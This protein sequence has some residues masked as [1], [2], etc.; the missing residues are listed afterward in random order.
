MVY[1][2]SGWLVV[3]FAAY[4]GLAIRSFLMQHLHGRHMKYPFDTFVISP[5]FMLA[6]AGAG[7]VMI[8]AGAARQ[9][10]ENGEQH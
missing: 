9:S 7:M 10:N 8:R 5:L 6:I 4:G 3:S 2:V 1:R